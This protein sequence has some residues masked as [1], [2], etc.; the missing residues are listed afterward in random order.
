MRLIDADEIMPSLRLLWILGGV[1]FGEGV[2]RAE[3]IINNAPTIEAEPVQHG[4][5]LDDNRRPKSSRFVCSVCGEV[6]YYP[7][8]HRGD[9]PRACGYLYCPNCGARMEREE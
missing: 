5:W 2:K 9:Q 1:S 8:N 6:A 3:E 7:Q 4:R